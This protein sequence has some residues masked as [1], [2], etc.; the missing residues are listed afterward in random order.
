MAD[1][2]A[3][4]RG[5][6]YHTT[7]RLASSSLPAGRA[8]LLHLRLSGSLQATLYLVELAVMIMT[9]VPH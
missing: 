5:E 7:M 9:D 4:E 6:Q 8:L 3:K 1:G 2:S